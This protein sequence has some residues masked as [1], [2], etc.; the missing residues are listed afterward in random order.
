MAEFIKAWLTVL[1]MTVFVCLGMNLMM[2]SL[3]K[4]RAEEYKAS[5]IA[6]IENSNFNQQV[7]EQCQKKAKE[8]GYELV[9]QLSSL[10]HHRMLANVVLKYHYRLPLLG[11]DQEYMLKGVAR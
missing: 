3:E 7:I 4:D 11:V 1:C 8:S 9:V 2:A 5:F 6:E 10:D